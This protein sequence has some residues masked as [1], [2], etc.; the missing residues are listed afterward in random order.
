MKLS[1]LIS[2]YDE[3]RAFRTKKEIDRLIEKLNREAHRSEIRGIV[4]VYQAQSERTQVALSLAGL[5]PQVLPDTGRGRTAESSRYSEKNAITSL[6]RIVAE[7]IRRATN[8]IKKNVDFMFYMIRNAFSQVRSVRSWD[9]RD[10]EVISNL[11]DKAIYAGASV[12]ELTKLVR[13]H[14]NS[15]MEDVK[16]INI[17]GR[18]YNIRKYAQ[19]CARTRMRVVQTRA[20][21]DQ[22]NRYQNDLVRFSKHMGAC[23]KCVPYEGRV[24]SLTGRDPKY[25]LLPIY[26]PVHPRC[27]HNIYPTSRL[28]IAEQGEVW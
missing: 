22:C 21:V 14:F 3:V 10:E 16:F 23:E 12:G 19:L 25:P 28:A 6:T 7:D 24:Y 15:L 20:I 5:R 17:N 13:I 1:E 4:D 26:P 11:L 27:Q 9:M 18:N 8:G 2:S